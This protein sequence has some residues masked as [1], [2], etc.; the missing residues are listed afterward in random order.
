MSEIALKNEQINRFF[1]GE[2]NLDLPFD[3]TLKESSMGE[4]SHF[5]CLEVLRILPGKRLVLKAVKDRQNVLIK[6]FPPIPKGN[7][8][9]QAEV[10][11]HALSVASGLNVS[12]LVLSYENIGEYYSVV[13]EFLDNAKPFSDRELWQSEDNIIKLFEMMVTMHKYGIYQHDIHLDNVLFKD[14]AISL[15]DFGSVWCEKE[16]KSLSRRKSL[17]NLAK[18]VA[19]FP[20]LEQPRIIKFVSR[21]YKLR[22]WP[23][24][25]EQPDVFLKSLN[26]IRKKRKKDSRKKSL[27]DCTRVKYGHNFLI[28]YA[29]L[30]EYI[31]NISTDD[32]IENID[33]I[34]AKG[35]ILKAGN[36]AT[37]VKVIINDMPLVIKRY[38]M[39]NKWH[40]LRR[41][42][43]ASRAAVSWRN[44][45]LLEFI[46]VPTAKQ[47]GFIER[48]IGWFRHTAYFISEY[49]EAEELLDVYQRRSPTENELEQIKN[50][51]LLLESHQVS[52]GDLKA[53]NLLINSRGEIL[54]IDLDSMK[55][56]KNS[57]VF[58]RAFDKDK[59]RFIRNWQ[60]LDIQ[61]TFSSLILP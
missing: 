16:G 48:R 26:I 18:L 1:R 36:S 8:Q 32:L 49:Q 50:I 3:L 34:M 15:I 35:E 14:G 23:W 58:Q 27:R 46:R 59:K 39:K 33:Q 41:C 61:E 43:R 52:H 17:N 6:F 24:D 55:E 11:G 12:D 2:R 5:H 9:Y 28:E 53:Q 42:F 47:F 4:E 29:F 19:Q 7:R 51:F 22:Q 56:H 10:R 45:N 40:L 54:L 13:Y 57:A 30:R 21:Y 25:D 38:N 60:D 37:V 44:A 31:Q 20:P